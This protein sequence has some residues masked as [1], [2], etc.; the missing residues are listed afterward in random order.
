MIFPIARVKNKLNAMVS[1]YSNQAKTTAVALAAVLEAINED[2]LEAAVKYANESSKKTMI[3]PKHI[4]RG[5]I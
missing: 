3:K 5:I 2:A 1:G 4:I